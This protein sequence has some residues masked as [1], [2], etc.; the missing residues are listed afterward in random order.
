MWKECPN[1]GFVE[2]HVFHVFEKSDAAQIDATENCN[3]WAL[4]CSNMANGLR[5]YILISN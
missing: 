5:A 4:S 3:S 2:P 1:H